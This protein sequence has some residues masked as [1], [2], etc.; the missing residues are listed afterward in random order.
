M[1]KPCDSVVDG[2]MDLS[3]ELGADVDIDAVLAPVPA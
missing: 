3:C 1:D 2:D